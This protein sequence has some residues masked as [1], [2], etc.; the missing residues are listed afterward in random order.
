MKHE[1]RNK[2]CCIYNL[3]DSRKLQV[4]V[5]GNSWFTKKK[6]QELIVLDLLQNMENSYSSGIQLG[7][8]LVEKRGVNNFTKIIKSEPKFSDIIQQPRADYSQTRTIECVEGSDGGG[9]WDY[10]YKL[11]P[12]CISKLN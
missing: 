12:A 11:P 8:I 6:E 1:N 4:V 7:A 9:Y 10:R 2:I 3:E 5:L